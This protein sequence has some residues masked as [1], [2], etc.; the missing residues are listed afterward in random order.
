MSERFQA[1]T[2]PVF[3]YPYRIFYGDTDAGGVVYYAQ[4]LRMF[5]Q[6]RGY[7][8]EEFGLT[9]VELEEKNCLFV[10]R[11]AEVDYHA[12]GR[13]GDELEIKI[14][15]SEAGRSFLTFAY[16]VTCPNRPG[17]DGGPAKIVSGLTKMVGCA[18]KRGKLSPQRIP[19]WVL[20][21]F[22]EGPI[23]RDKKKSARKASIPN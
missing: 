20:H 23:H 6:A 7:Y 16:E 19:D 10:C 22:A 12:P 11:R 3:A 5:E 21:R 15:V 2:F 8:I 13:L 18:E 1:I 14:W 9:L 17:A 4:Y